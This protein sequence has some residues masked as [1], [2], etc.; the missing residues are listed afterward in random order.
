MSMRI[1]LWIAHSTPWK[2]KICGSNGWHTCRHAQ[3][4]VSSWF[5]LRIQSR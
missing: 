3:L 4:L 5:A 1:L 2:R